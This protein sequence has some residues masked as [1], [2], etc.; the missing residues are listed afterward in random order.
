VAYARVETIVA[1]TSYRIVSDYA[2][3]AYEGTHNLAL[4]VTMVNYPKSS[5]LSH[6]TLLSNF[7]LTITP[8]V[9]DCKLLNWNMPG[10]QSLT[11]TVLKEV[12]ESLTI[13]HATVDAASKTTTPAIRACYRTDVSPPGP[14]CNEAT[15]ITDVVVKATLILPGFIERAGDVLTVKGTSNTQSGVYV[16]QVTHDT[17]FEDAPIVFDTVTIRIND[18]VITDID[19]PTNPGA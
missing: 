2:L 4:Y 6:P 13:L 15:A 7:D 8:A 14:G 10:A 9:C 17:Q 1:N 12:S 11:T 19:S 16:M 3:E 18:C 5:S